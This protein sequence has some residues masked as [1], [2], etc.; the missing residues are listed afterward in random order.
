[1][2]PTRR[3]L[4]RLGG[5]AVTGFFAGCVSN[6][7][8]PNTTEPT[9]TDG[10]MP[11]SNDTTDN[12]AG[13]TRPA[14]TG[15]PGLFLHATDTQPALPLKLAVSV[16]HDVAT[17]DAPPQLKVTLTN[18]S[19]EQLTVG[20]GRAIF[21]QYRMDDDNQLML[22]PAADRYDAKPGC[23]RLNE[24][25]AVTEE[26]RTRTVDPGVSIS[27][28]VDLYGAPEGEGCLPVGNFHFTTSYNVVP[29]ESMET[30]AQ[31]SAEWGFTVTLE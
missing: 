8:D 4:L 31:E 13:G 10:G 6:D 1:M 19:D 29:T 21:F 27:E 30:A 15:G 18:T 7:A 14:G 9:S 24:P 11:G 25:I 20:E 5:L 26:Y 22:L 23:W 2:S 12:G 17:E 16:T 28:K 3:S